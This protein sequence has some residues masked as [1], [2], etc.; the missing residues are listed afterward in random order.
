MTHWKI[1]KIEVSTEFRLGSEQ[2][3]NDYKEIQRDSLS[4][5]KTID[6]ENFYI[7]IDEITPE[8]LSG[9]IY[10][11]YDV[12]KLNGGSFALSIDR[13]SYSTPIL[14]VS[15]DT[16]CQLTI[17]LVYEELPMD[18]I[19]ITLTE[20]DTDLAEI[21]PPASDEAIAKCNEQLK[22]YHLTN[23][24]QEYAQFLKISDGM[25]FNGM[26]MFGTLGN[27]IV[28]QNEQMRNY[29]SHY[30]GSENLLIIGRIDDDI[31]TYNA[32]T[33]HYEARDINGF[34]IWDEYDSFEAFFFQ[35]M[36]K[37]LRK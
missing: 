10:W 23:I 31:Y 25:E 20:L 11:Q 5:G 3:W 21:M 16:H 36:M 24:P 8:S 6:F 2:N 30:K 28:L 13:N 18:K 19:K 12:L 32:S 29:Y 14:N 17:S 35:E 9:M 27:D 4:V 22:H 15:D 33:H 7:Q 37:W 1:L 26:Q 34:E